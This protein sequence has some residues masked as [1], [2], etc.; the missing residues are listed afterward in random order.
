MTLTVIICLQ[1]C[2]VSWNVFPSLLPHTFLR[3]TLDYN[4]AIYSD[5][6]MTLQPG[7]TLLGIRKNYLW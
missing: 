1:D 3:K 2:I 5:P 4:D 7:S 6:F